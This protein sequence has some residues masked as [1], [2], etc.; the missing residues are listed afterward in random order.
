MSTHPRAATWGRRYTNGSGRTR[1]RRPGISGGLPAHLREPGSRTI[2]DLTA[3]MATT[4]NIT[5]HQQG[6]SRAGSTPLKVSP[7]TTDTAS[8]AAFLAADRGR[9]MTGTVLN[10]SAGTG[11]D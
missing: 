1:R 2:E 4:I 5:Q 6:V 8:A 3:G 9:M 10:A 11:T 7:R